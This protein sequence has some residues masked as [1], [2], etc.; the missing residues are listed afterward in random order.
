MPVKTQAFV[1]GDDQIRTGV[2]GFAGLCL[3]TRPRRH[4]L[5]Q[6]S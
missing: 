1:R 5:K 4:N 3:A 6:Y 2:Q